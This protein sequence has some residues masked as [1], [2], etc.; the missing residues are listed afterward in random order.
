LGNARNVIGMFALA[1]NAIGLGMP[2][3]SGCYYHNALRRAES[4]ILH[5][6][7]SSVFGKGLGY[8][9]RSGFHDAVQ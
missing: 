6:Q 2:I 1:E 7:F 4:K 8:L 5:F 3:F 9:K